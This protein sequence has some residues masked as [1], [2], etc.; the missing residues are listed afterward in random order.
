MPLADSRGNFKLLL[1][2]IFN[3]FFVHF[4]HFNLLIHIYLIDLIC[5]CLII[6]SFLIFA[7]LIP[8]SFQISPKHPNHW[9]LQDTIAY[10]RVKEEETFTFWWSFPIVCIAAFCI[11][12]CVLGFYSM[13]KRKLSESN[14]LKEKV[15]EKVSNLVYRSFKPYVVTEVEYKPFREMESTV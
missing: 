9:S 1:Q 7:D 5:F 6:R 3:A 10:Q 4:C 13:K 2:R 12:L 14:K 8:K 11:L 15:N